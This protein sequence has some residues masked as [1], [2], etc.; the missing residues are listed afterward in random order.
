MA[1]FRYCLYFTIRLEP[2]WR[3]SSQHGWPEFSQD[4]FTRTLFYISFAKLYGLAWGFKELA[5]AS[6]LIQC[7]CAR[8]WGVMYFNPC[9]FPILFYIWR[10]ARHVFHAN[11]WKRCSEFLWRCDCPWHIIFSYIFT[12]WPR[13]SNSDCGAVVT[14][15][16]VGILLRFQRPNYRHQYSAKRTVINHGWCA[17]LATSRFME[18]YDISRPWWGP[19]SM[20]CTFTLCCDHLS[21]VP[22]LA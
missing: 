16:P 12:S 5:F 1:S 17:L 18:W 7:F 4:L 21:Y 10:F 14:S 9:T 13:N 11:R 6:G 3:E 19:P 20:L 15:P 22:L 2:V 8:P